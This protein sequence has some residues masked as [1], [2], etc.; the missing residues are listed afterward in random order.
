MEE[1]NKPKN[2]GCVI[3]LIV[4]VVVGAIWYFT[5]PVSKNNNEEPN[6][7]AVAADFIKEDLNYPDESDISAFDCHSTIEN[8]GSYTVLQKFSAKN[9]FGMQKTYIY[10]LNFIYLGGIEYDKSSWSLE[11]KRSE[12][13]K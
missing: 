12:V 2:N 3:A 5:R 11:S 9:A 8:N 10:K 7:C 1:K 6:P 4:F 13:V